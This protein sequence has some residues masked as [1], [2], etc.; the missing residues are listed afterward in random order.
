MSN[1]TEQLQLQLPT[2][3]EKLLEIAEAAE[4]LWGTRAEVRV[5]GATWLNFYPKDSE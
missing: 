1:P 5:M 4:R 2:S 3:G